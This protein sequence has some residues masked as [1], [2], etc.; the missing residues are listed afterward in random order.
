M[1]LQLDIDTKTFLRFWLVVIGLFLAAYVIH[2]AQTALIIIGSALFLALGLNTPVS[3]I[4]K[5]L[6]SKSRVIPTALAYVVVVAILVA[7]F[8]FVIPPI[9]QQ[10]AKFLQTVPAL[11]QSF[12]TQWKGLSRII[13]DYNLQPQLDSATAA[14]QS[15]AAGWAGDLGSNFISGIGSVVSFVTQALLVLV[16]TFL[17]LV[18]A[19]AWKQRLL[20]LYSDEN[21]MNQHKKVLS[22]MYGVVTGYI[23]GQLTVSALGA[24][25]AGTMVFILSFVFHEIPASLAVPAVA[26]SFL[27][28]LIPLFGTTIG[29]LIIGLLL[30]FNWAP[31][32]ISYLIFFIVYQQIENNFIAPHIQSK[33][34]NL[35]ALAVLISITI[36]IYVFGLA[37]GIIAIPIAGCIR[38]LVDEYAL[39]AVEKRKA[40]VK[41]AKA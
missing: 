7:I 12:T 38:V 29:G 16:L 27:F 20:N 17:M 2:A 28:S 11:V 26:I 35:S 30:L 10:T 6:P 15:S 41:K 40:E 8:L 19:P 22:K 3:K 9:A 18:E 37:G 24:L 23:T 21:R 13:T 1:K 25:A 14:I 36:G 5:R 33:K 32:A 34:L 39:T 4:A 31:A